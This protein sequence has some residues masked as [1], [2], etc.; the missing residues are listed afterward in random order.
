MQNEDQ[1]LDASIKLLDIYTGQ[2]IQALEKTVVKLFETIEEIIE[3]DEQGK[4][5]QEQDLTSPEMM[6]PGF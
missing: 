6:Y 3:A 5:V 4:K 1:R 2:E